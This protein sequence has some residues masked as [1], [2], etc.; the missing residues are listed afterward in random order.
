MIKLQIYIVILDGPFGAVH[1]WRGEDTL[2]KKRS[3]PLSI[4][5]VNVT[6]LLKKSLMENYIFC[7]VGAIRPAAT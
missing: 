6:H 3:F 4:S 5:S 1:G 2:R 7:A